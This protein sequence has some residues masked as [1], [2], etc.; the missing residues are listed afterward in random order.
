M[1]M[2]MTHLG[3]IMLTEPREGIVNINCFGLCNIPSN[4]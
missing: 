1:N 4:F 3:Y 2:L